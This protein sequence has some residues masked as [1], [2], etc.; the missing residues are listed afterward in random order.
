MAILPKA[1]YRF[2][3]IPI[4]IPTQFFNELERTICRFIRNNKNPR[5]AKTLLK[6]KK[7]SGG[8]TMPDL[9]LYY[10]PIV[11]KTCGIGIVTDK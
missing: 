3:A 10:R 5:I 2:N 8:I 9:T 1:I 7:S 4:K 6:D 11:T